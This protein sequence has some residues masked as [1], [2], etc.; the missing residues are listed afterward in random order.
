MAQLSKQVQ[1]MSSTA[2]ALHAQHVTFLATLFT[3]CELDDDVLND[4]HFGA[5]SMNFGLSVLQEHLL[6]VR[7]TLMRSVSDNG[8][9]DSVNITQILRVLHQGIQMGM[10]EIYLQH[11]MSFRMTGTRLTWKS[12]SEQSELYFQNIFGDL[13]QRLRFF[14]TDKH[15]DDRDV[16]HPH[17]IQRGMN[18]VMIALIRMYIGGDYIRDHFYRYENVISLFLD[19]IEVL[20]QRSIAGNWKE[21]SA[22]RD[23]SER[24]MTSISKPHSN[25]KTSETWS[26]LKRFLIPKSMGKL[27]NVRQTTTTLYPHSFEGTVD[28]R[29]LQL[30]TDFTELQATINFA[31]PI[32][33]TL[34]GAMQQT[35][36]NLLES[37]ESDARDTVENLLLQFPIVHAALETYDLPYIRCSICNVPV[38]FEVFDSMQQEILNSESVL[39]N[40]EYQCSCSHHFGR[41]LLN[42]AKKKRALLSWSQMVQ[43]INAVTH[44]MRILWNLHVSSHTPL[45]LDSRISSREDRLIDWLILC[46]VHEQHIDDILETMRS[47]SSFEN[48]SYHREWWRRTLEAVIGKVI[49]NAILHFDFGSL[50]VTKAEVEKKFSL[51]IRP[52]QQNSS[53]WAR[54]IPKNFNTEVWGE[55]QGEYSF[56]H[57]TLQDYLHVLLDIRSPG[58]EKAQMLHSIRDSYLN[59]VERWNENTDRIALNLQ[60]LLMEYAGLVRQDVIFETHVRGEYQIL[61]DV[62]TE[63]V[64]LLFEQGT[65]GKV[66]TG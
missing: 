13:D 42:K 24:L 22:V 21:N 5:K 58:K 18:A 37:Y 29:L 46:E 9:H 23:R 14:G 11:A 3:E 57:C 41:F 33:N 28:D 66:I 19:Y 2:K 27:A 20:L 34:Q 4:V 65:N 6:Q 10:T 50:F 12:I 26:H 44:D 32:E 55:F 51:C 54:I 62:F 63:W 40:V 43:I 38:P 25:A 61:A 39:P 16:L 49:Y 45:K 8:E 52:F 1:W 56:V 35:S 7:E 53:I 15:F 64:L 30:I 47:T 59:S 36:F 31:L 48:A 17:V 60:A